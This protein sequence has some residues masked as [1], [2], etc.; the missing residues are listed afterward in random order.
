MN[1]K[2]RVEKVE[3]AA[4]GIRGEPPWLL[5]CYDG[6]KK[7]SRAEIEAMKVVHKQQNPDWDKRP[8]NVLV[9]TSE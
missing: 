3:E 5:L 7:A 4:R 8:F 6:D 2:A 9:Y 1:M